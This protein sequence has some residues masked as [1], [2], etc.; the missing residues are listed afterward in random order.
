MQG[1]PCY[2]YSTLLIYRATGYFRF[3]KFALAV[4]LRERG[5]LIMVV[6]EKARYAIASLND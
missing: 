6:P 3:L 2:P 5:I 1:R 4:L